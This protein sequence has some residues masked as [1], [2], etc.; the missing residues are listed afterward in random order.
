MAFI[1]AL[2]GH[3]E[4]R[5]MMETKW[6]RDEDGNDEET[7]AYSWIREQYNRTGKE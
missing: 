6:N 2:I 1:D 7:K 3:R 4:I 5:R